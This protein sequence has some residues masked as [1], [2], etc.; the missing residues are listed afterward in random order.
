[1][2]FADN[3]KLGGT[4]K[5]RSQIQNNLG[6]LDSLGGAKKKFNEKK[7]VLLKNNKLHEY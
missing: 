2:F 5:E 1:M 3:T 4:L 6:K 7:W